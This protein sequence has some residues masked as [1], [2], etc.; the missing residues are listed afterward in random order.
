MSELLPGDPNSP[1]EPTLIINTDTMRANG[2]GGCNSYSC[3][4]TSVDGFTISFNNFI[5]TKAYCGEELSSN[6]GQ[7]LTLLGNTNRW[8]M[9][10]D[11]LR[12]LTTDDKEITLTGNPSQSEPEPEPEPEPETPEDLVRRIQQEVDDDTDMWDESDIAEL[13]EPYLITIDGTR[14]LSVMPND[15]VPSSDH[16][17]GETGVKG[18]RQS[19]DLYPEGHEYHDM[20]YIEEYFD[21]YPNN[22]E[23]I[24]SELKI[25]MYK[26]KAYDRSTA[27]T[28]ILFSVTFEQ[29]RN[30]QQ[31]I[32]IAHDIY[33][34]LYAVGFRDTSF[35]GVEGGK[36]GG[37]GARNTVFD[38]FRKV[39]AQQINTNAA[40]W[41]VDIFQMDP[42][43]NKLIKL[44]NLGRFNGTYRNLRSI[45][46]L[47]EE[48]WGFFIEETAYDDD[49]LGNFGYVYLE[50]IEREGLFDKLK[51]ITKTLI[52]IAVSY[53]VGNILGDVISGV[54]G[55]LQGAQNAKNL[56]DLLDLK[57]I[58]DETQGAFKI[59]FD[60][61]NIRNVNESLNNVFRGSVNYK[62]YIDD[63]FDDTDNFN[64]TTFLN[65]I[66]I[67]D[68][69]RKTLNMLLVQQDLNG[70][71]VKK[72]IFLVHEIINNANK[73]ESYEEFRD[74]A[75]EQGWTI[76]ELRK[77]I[78]FLYKTSNV[79]SVM[80][81][82]VDES[83]DSIYTQE[84]IANIIELLS[85]I[86]NIAEWYDKVH[87]IYYGPIIDVLSNT[88]NIP[89]V[90]DDNSGNL[91]SLIVTMFHHNTGNYDEFKEQA[92]N[93]GHYLA[94][95]E[96]I[97]YLLNYPNYI[98][99][100]AR[101]NDVS[102]DVINQILDIL[103]N[104]PEYIPIWF[105]EIFKKSPD[106]DEPEF[107]SEPEPEAGSES[108]D[109]VVDDDD[110]LLI[111][112][113][114]K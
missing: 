43:N 34:Y 76:T 82:A 40:I 44:R 29:Q 45:L 30:F 68:I 90:N 26:R 93:D 60:L 41:G 65:E 12:L 85:G 55:G 4:I 35:T 70:K 16:P 114:L 73:Y 13:L 31:F 87:W 42:N 110:D 88:L 86:P 27:A 23:I 18:Y 54:F 14:F 59:L 97:I 66:L 113:R 52:K 8:N 56:E 10:N 78:D 106:D 101:E 9:N 91:S 75:L 94:H 57:N 5:T 69:I 92:F 11:Q 48:D 33:D 36:S 37:G 53:A 99:D 71:P 96:S 111:Y 46:G 107:R 105:E 98:A 84:Q 50:Y 15:W 72:Y 104:L 25:V 100:I 89:I 58:W 24:P 79:A 63:M 83:G 1:Y 109:V 61:K 74:N 51:D 19:K 64:E 80:N 6:E 112:L 103:N 3:D 7:F 62:A 102:N 20:N 17:T 39:F 67:S 49:N 47:D 32:Q 95:V 81:N 22:S 28:N 108:E 38:S 21:T 77:I 2:F